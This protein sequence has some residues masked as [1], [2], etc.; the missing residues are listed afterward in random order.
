M[1]SGG[2]AQTPLLVKIAYFTAL[3]FI[4]IAV[5][6]GCV[7]AGTRNPNMLVVASAAG[8]AG[9]F[10]AVGLAILVAVGWYVAKKPAADAPAP[11]KPA[12]PA[13]AKPVPPANPRVSREASA[14]RSSQR[15]RK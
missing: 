2:A 12:A 7:Y 10:C 3:A 11:P 1:N 4:T 15:A 8:A 6:A 13:D 9:A 5:G 14:R